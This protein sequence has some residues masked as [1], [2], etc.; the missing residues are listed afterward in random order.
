MSQQKSSESMLVVDDSNS[1]LE[2][3]KQ[4]SLRSANVNLKEPDYVER[5][6]QKITEQR[7]NLLT[8]MSIYIILNW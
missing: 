1:T 8:M 4:L 6:T 3:M 7:F 5:K 2:V